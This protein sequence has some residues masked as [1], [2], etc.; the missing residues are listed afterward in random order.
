V[1]CVEKKRGLHERKGCAGGL[2]GGG[3]LGVRYRNETGRSRLENLGTQEVTSRATSILKTLIKRTRDQREGGLDSL[4]NSLARGQ[5]K[6]ELKGEFFT[7]NKHRSELM[8]QRQRTWGRAKKKTLRLSIRS[9]RR[10][11][12]SQ[13]LNTSV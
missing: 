3:G 4:W 8:G 9:S 12:L 6:G 13:E 1:V 11:R 10:G 5:G 7:T 2:W